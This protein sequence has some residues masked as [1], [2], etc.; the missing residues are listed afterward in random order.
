MATTRMTVDALR[1]QVARIEA[2]VHTQVS[3]LDVELGT[4]VEANTT[5]LTLLAEAFLLL[6]SQRDLME[7]RKRMDTLLDKVLVM[8]KEF[9][10]RAMVHGTPFALDT[11]PAKV[12]VPEPKPFGGAWNAKDVENF[13]WNMEQYFVA[14]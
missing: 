6:G 13:L 9:L 14:A 5:L 2:K 10:K 7:T 3:T 1:V 4:T 11:P 12:R 8:T